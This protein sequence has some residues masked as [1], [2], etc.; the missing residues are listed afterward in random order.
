M[1]LLHLPAAA[2]VIERVEVLELGGHHLVR[3][4]D[5]DG[6]CGYSVPNQHLPHLLGM[7]QRLVAP[8][9]I[10]AD[11]RALESIVAS[12]SAHGSTYK[13]AG[14][15][16]WCPVGWVEA[17]VLDLLGRRSL[18]RVADLLGEVERCRLPFYVSSMRRDSPPEEEVDHLA[19]RLAQTGATV[20][21]LKIG[22][23]MSGNADAH[24]GRTEALIALARR[25]L[26]PGIALGADANGSYDQAHAIS[27]GLRLEGHEYTWFEEPCPFEDYAATRAVAEALRIPVSAG[28][29]DS[30]LWHFADLAASVDIVQC[31]AMYVGGLL[32]AR[33][34]CAMAAAA[35]KPVLPHSPQGR[36][37]LIYALHLAAS[38][39]VVGPWL[40]ANTELGGHPCVPDIPMADGH[41]QL[42]EGSGF[43]F[44]V[45]ESAWAAARIVMQ[46]G[47]STAA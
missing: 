44:A 4:R 45:D 10:G 23:R 14:L 5:R 26:G 37:A 46:V 39:P 42:P 16:L 27:M 15:A 24:P 9:F 25:R 38:T 6:G 35:G 19:E 47:G 17:A 32:R 13:L 7:L 28:E 3:V 34:V 8:R 29:Q 43:G 21:K 18:R 22:G 12:V 30:S 40:E 31:D 2:V 11:A 33:Q 41:L 36:A 20:A 1:R